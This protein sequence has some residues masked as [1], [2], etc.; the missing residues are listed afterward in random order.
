[1]KKVLWALMALVL[2]TTPTLAEL[3]QQPGS[4]LFDM[5]KAQK[6]IEIDGTSPG[7]IAALPGISEFKNEIYFFFFEDLRLVDVFLGLAGKNSI[8]PA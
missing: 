1:M 4:A 2:I 3:P 6:E 5:K 7:R 8:T